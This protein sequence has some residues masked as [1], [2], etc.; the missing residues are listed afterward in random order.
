MI[1]FPKINSGAK[2]KVIK[3]WAPIF[4]EV[5]RIASEVEALYVQAPVV[6]QLP[7]SSASVQE[8]ARSIRAGFV[9]TFEV[10]Q[11]K[12]LI[13]RYMIEQLSL[14]ANYTNPESIVQLLQET[15][16]VEASAQDKLQRI[17]Y[18]LSIL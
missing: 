9:P 1:L 16:M 6:R 14:R 8:I 18:L 13:D 2:D 3:D 10:L 17:R 4:T 5:Q 15:L 7:I 11:S 12:M